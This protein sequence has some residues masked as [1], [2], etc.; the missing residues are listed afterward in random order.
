MPRKS[1][2]AEKAASPL[3]RYN[4]KRNFGK[5]PEPGSKVSRR[6]GSSFVVQEHHARAHHFDFRLEMDG[7]L[8][9]WAVPKGIPED[10]SEKRL[11]VHV[12][13]HPLEY[14]KFEGTIPKGNYGAGRVKIWDKGLWEPID[15]D[16]RKSFKRGKMKFMLKGGRLAGPYALIRMREEPNWILRKLDDDAAPP[17]SGD[18]QRET[19]GF[20]SP[21]LARVVPTVP[22]GSH[23][24]HELKFDGYRLIAVKRSG[25]VRLFTR[26]AIDWTDRFVGLAKHLAEIADVDF[27]IDGEAVVFDR[28]GRSDFG[29]LQAAL[30][31]GDGD[32][33][34]YVIFDLPHLDGR[35][36]RNLPLSERQRQLAE[37]VPDEGGVIRRSTAWPAEAGGELFRQAC[38]NGLEGIISKNVKGRYIEGSRRD[39]VKSKCR[40]RQEFV[41]CGHT[42]PKGSLSGF[43]ALVLGSFEN[44]QLVHRGKVGTGFSDRERSR[45]LDILTPL[46]VNS[47]PFASDERDVTWL[48]PKLI[49]EIEFAEITRDG[50][51]RQGSFIALR[52]DKKASEVRLEALQTA[53]GKPEVAGVVISHPDRLVY[54]GDQITKMEVAGYYERIGDLM[55][56]FVSNR[57]LAVI[58]APEGITGETFF[59]KSFPTHVPKHVIQSRLDDGTTIFSVRKAEGLVALAQFGMIEVHPWGARLPDVDK[60]DY[61]TWDLDPDDSVPWKEVLGAALLL[62]DVLAQRGL[63]T[64]VKTSG[65]KGLHIMLQLRRT[66]SWDVMKPFAK[67]IAGVVAEMNPRRLTI[68]STKAKRKGKIYIDWMRNGRGATCIAPWGLR[69][70]PGAPVSMPVAWSQLPDINAAGFTIRGAME[71]P[72]EWMEMKPQTVGKTV[73][74]ELGVA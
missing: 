61:L 9:S 25:K 54:P 24:L 58:R 16:W 37:L 63:S 51:I 30:R 6:K 32:S 65:G 67:A 50:R 13:D 1:P 52:E 12:E 33:I 2:P 27:V 41:V 23:W 55:L 47:A 11:A 22:T 7:V 70:R 39:W 74:R 28:K 19:A 72:S 73:L 68:T 29:R 48:Q 46:R 62:R 64:V 40:A 14:G 38:E 31:D 3:E 44:G 53:S 56:P 10:T 43:G 42:P 15:T 57:P 17:A 71:T 20:V 66:H 18:L 26:N 69:A 21:Q 4:K 8:A 34:S 60:P 36:L 5:T 35:N 59:Q 49:A 45:L